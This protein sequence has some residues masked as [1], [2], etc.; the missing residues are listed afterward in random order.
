MTSF[1]K[2]I[3]NVSFQIHDYPKDEFTIFPENREYKFG[4][5]KLEIESMP[6]S[7]QTQYIHSNN[8]MSG[9]MSDECQDG[10]SKMQHL[11]HTTKNILTILSL[12]SDNIDVFVETYGF[13][14][15]IEEIFPLTK[16]T[17]NNL[18]ELHKNIDTKLYPR[19]STNIEAALKNAYIQMSSSLAQYQKTQI[20]MTDGNITE[21]EK[22]CDKLYNLVNQEYNNIF[23]GFGQDHDAILLQRLASKKNGSYYFIDKIEN[24]GM[25]FGEILH[26]I[27]YTVLKDTI[28]SIE[29]GEIYNYA[30]DVW[31]NS[32]EIGNIVGEANKTYHIRSTAPEVMKIILTAIEIDKSISIIEDITANISEPFTNLT[33]YML[34]Q[35]TQEILHIASHATEDVEDVEDVDKKQN[36]KIFAEFLE[37]Y[38]KINN[39][40]EDEFHKTLYTDIKIAQNTMGT[41]MAAMYCG[42]RSQSQGRERSYNVAPPKLRRNNKI[43]RF[44]NINEQ[45]Q[46][47]DTFDDFT[48]HQLNRTNTT[49]SQIKMMKSVSGQSVTFDAEE[50]FSDIML[51]TS[52]ATQNIL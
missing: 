13:D 48:S 21:G 52:S 1:S 9:S 37:N 40:E 6:I 4:V 25:V 45:N 36:I 24:A 11:I 33:K 10:R 28:I 30:T 7:N 34:R 50:N 8:D 14:S 26:S 43:N 22:S 23:V 15:K 41:S 19:N 12:N 5:I 16:I 49:P 18:A 39:L 27:L 17:G 20:F 29:N 44:G 2:T 32:L 47:I 46:L 3:K 35:R 42:A 51:N 31:S 38:M